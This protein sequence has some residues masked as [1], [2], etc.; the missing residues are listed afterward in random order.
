MELQGTRVL[1]VDRDADTV[2][3]IRRILRASGA[4]VT[5]VR[6]GRDVA[7]LLRQ[8]QT[9]VLLVDIGAARDGFAVMR[10]VRQLSPQDGGRIPSA[11]LGP[12]LLHD[13]LLD[14][15]R[16]SGFQLHVS[17]PLD[18]IELTAV[19]EILSGRSIERRRE[20]RHATG[21]AERRMGFAL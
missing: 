20:T 15:W 8:A 14:D 13:H 7:P 4:Q 6:S 5:G 17:K 9:D 1:V 3:A 12:S 11:S 18:P 19:V 21:R 2:E 10:E 16:R